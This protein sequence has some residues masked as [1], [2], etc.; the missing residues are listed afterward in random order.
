VGRWQL[1]AEAASAM[2]A[3]KRVGPNEVDAPV[4]LAL[5]RV[6]EWAEQFR[7]IPFLDG[8]LV[9]PVVSIGAGNVTFDHGLGRVPR[10]FIVVGND[11]PTAAAYPSMVSKDTKTIVM[12]FGGSTLGA[13]F[14]VWG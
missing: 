3:L 4:K 10:G 7:K 6:W 13:F 11:G 12:N 5:D 9:G 8:V 1:G 2:K 14:W